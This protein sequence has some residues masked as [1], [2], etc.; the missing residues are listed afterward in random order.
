M[1]TTNSSTII[2]R[3]TDGTLVDLQVAGVSQGSITVASG[4]VSYN[5][6][7]GSHYGLFSSGSAANAGE[8]VDLTGT[9]SYRDGSHE[10]IYGIIRSSTPNSPN[11]LGAYLSTSNP[12]QAPG[13]NNPE[14]IMA[15]GNGDVW[16]ADNGSGNVS[17]GDP[18][19]SSSVAGYAMRDPGTYAVSHIFAKAAENIDWSQVTTLVSGVKAA[20]ISVLFSYYDR[21]N[22]NNQLHAESI[23]VMN[24]AIFGGDVSIA[25]S[26]N[27]SGATVLSSLTVSGTAT[28]ANLKVTGN[29]EVASIKVN[30]KI[31]TGGNAPTI[32]AGVGA[33]TADSLNSIATPVVNVVGNDTSGTITVTVGAN[34][35]AD[36]LV[37]LVFASSFSNKPRVVLTPGNRDSAGLGLYYDEANSTKDGLSV[38]SSNAPETGKTYVFTYLIVE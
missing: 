32:S 8:L 14:L 15:A 26:L 24:S 31:I 9:N 7:T 38:L 3:A 23:E 35:A 4:T 16:V 11:I 5:A 17:I 1:D 22:T 37:K 19:L 29:L 12:D 36:E 30:G 18:L 10:P 2:N 21:D 25:S 13:S 20:K 34:T 33:G 6:F 27:V 28:L